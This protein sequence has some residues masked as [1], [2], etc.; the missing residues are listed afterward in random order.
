MEGCY[1]CHDEDKK[2]LH[3]GA[4]HKN[5]IDHTEMWG[6]NHQSAG[7]NNKS[8]KRRALIV[9]SFKKRVK[10]GESAHIVCKALQREYKYKSVWGVH[11]HLRAAGVM[12]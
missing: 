4:L 6:P 3:R 7:T 11:A 10:A 9:R 5:C 1:F 8:L 12:R 2:G